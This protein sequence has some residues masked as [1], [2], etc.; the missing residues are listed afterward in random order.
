MNGYKVLSYCCLMFLLFS[1]KDEPN[2]TT[3]IVENQQTEKETI[4]STEEESATKR[5][6]NLDSDSSLISWTGSKPAGNHNGK[7]K[8]KSGEINFKGDKLISGK[9]IIDMESITVLDL[10][11]DEK[12][13]LENHLKGNIEG[14]E[15]HFFNVKKYPEAV[16]VI[17][18]V[19]DKNNSNVVYGEL[20]IKGISNPIEF[21][22]DISF[23]KDFEI[24]KLTT[25][26][27]EIDRTIWGIEYMSKSVFDDLKERFIYDEI[28]LQVILKASNI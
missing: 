25:E 5:Q 24:M 16:F 23:S 15:D 18:S 10:E 14:K 1:C 17:K 3:E 13:D 2:K 9:F 4:V 11:G 20:T 26:N 8:I 22:S 27:F 19:M 7:I 12:L 21:K 6:Y 28:G